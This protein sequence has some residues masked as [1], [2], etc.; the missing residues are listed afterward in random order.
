MHGEI[1]AA[2]EELYSDQ[3]AEVVVQLAQHYAEAGQGEKAIP[4]LL[5]AG[6]QARLAYANEEAIAY[7]H[8]ALALL[9]EPSLIQFQKGWRLEALKGLDRYTMG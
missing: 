4:Y 6:D 3:T 2:L 8:R 9:D 5:R 7:F 1:A